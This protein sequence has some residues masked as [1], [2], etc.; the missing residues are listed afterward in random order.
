LKRPACFLL[1]VLAAAAAFPSAGRFLAYVTGPSVS[2]HYLPYNDR[3]NNF[4]LGL[5]VE[6]YFQKGRFLIGGNGHFM[7]NDSNDRAAFWIGVAPGYM[8]G[9]QEKLWASL[10]VI[11]GGLKKAEYNGGRFS[12][13][14]LPYL[15]MGFNRVGLNVGY[16]PRIRGVTAPILLVQLKFLAY[17]WRR[18]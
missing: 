8:A 5:G 17:P 11:A 9:N 14:A 13:F 2:K 10:A 3:F 12:A 16:I 15:A 7:F 6:A 18:L 4:H 1:I